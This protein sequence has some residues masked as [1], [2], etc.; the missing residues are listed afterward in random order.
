MAEQTHV[1]LGDVR[2]GDLRTRNGLDLRLRYSDEALE[3]WPVRRP[4]V[5]C[6][7]LL[8]RGP[9][10]ALPFA[11]GLLPEGDA[12]RAMAQE[13]GVVPDRTFELL[14][15]FGRDVAG[16]LVISDE[17]PTDRDGSAAIYDGSALGEAVSDLDQR[18]LD[19]HDDSE[20]SIAGFENKLLLIRTPDG[21]WARPV[22][23]MPST[24]ILK[25]DNRRHPGIVHAEA[26]ALRIAREIG[27]TTIVPQIQ[28][29]GAYDCL[30]V[31]R[32]DRTTEGGAT[33]RLHQEDLCQATG[34]SA[35]GHRGR[36]KYEQYGGPTFEDM[37][38]LLDAYAEQPTEQL[39]RLVEAMVFTV[40][41]GNGDAHG[42]NLSILH[43]APGTIEL[44]P[45]YDTVPTAL[46]PELKDRAAMR[47]N[48]REQLS[49][50][51]FDDLLREASRWPISRSQ[52]DRVLRSAIE[53]IADVAPRCGHDALTGF[54]RDRATSLRRA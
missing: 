37:A 2:V 50:V 24:H 13:A 5:S 42:K 48:G 26:A 45:L 38:E 33:R 20:L 35:Q 4:V 34:R 6:S 25:R 39:E 22:G 14:H 40:L 51:T 46:W 32:F 3:R 36:E 18:P 19:L 12:L 21:R 43:P 23:G 52:G 10:D 1:W 54:V 47:I 44:A 49:A 31:D 11:E 7:L 9:Q 17:Q 27:L 53:R 30:I 29:L 16:A 15:R 28:R 8:Q 41:I